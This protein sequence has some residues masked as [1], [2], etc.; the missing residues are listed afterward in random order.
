ME[1]TEVT[2]T[3][4]KIKKHKKFGSY[5]T[6]EKSS[7]FGLVRTWIFEKRRGNK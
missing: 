5:G 6:S 7:T 3:K 2:E 4:S 1:V